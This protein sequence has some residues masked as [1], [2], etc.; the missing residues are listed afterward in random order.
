M[1]K[2]A[3]HFN[4]EKPEL[5]HSVS[6]IYWQLEDYDEA[7]RANKQALRFGDLPAAEKMAEALKQKQGNSG[8]LSRFRR[9]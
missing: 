6:V 2:E 1:Y 4:K 9:G 5:W 8:L 7:G 3:L